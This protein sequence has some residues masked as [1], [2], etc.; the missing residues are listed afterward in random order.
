MTATRLPLD[1]AHALA[2]GWR[3][4]K[5]RRTWPPRTWPK[6]RES[7]SPHS[8]WIEAKVLSSHSHA[9]VLC[10]HPGAA[11]G[12]NE[13]S[14]GLARNTIG[15]A[16]LARAQFATACDG[17]RWKESAC[18]SPVV[19]KNRPLSVC[20]PPELQ[21]GGLPCPHRNPLKMLDTEKKTQGNAN[22]WRSFSTSRAG[23]RQGPCSH[24]KI[25]MA[26]LA[27]GGGATHALSRCRILGAQTSSNTGMRDHE[28]LNLRRK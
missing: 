26:G 23:A 27:D 19:S 10:S 8:L 28:R 9:F 1:Q 20:Q 24:A 7:T 25:R 2:A 17:A 13:A 12:V 4:E 6:P 5:T 16:I 18:A 21:V 11:G 14:T 3:G 22:S 15:K